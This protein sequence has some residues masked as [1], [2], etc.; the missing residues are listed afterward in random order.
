[1]ITQQQNSIN[2]PLININN[3][4]SGGR[5]LPTN[6]PIRS[7]SAIGSLGVGGPGTSDPSLHLNAQN[8]I[9][10]QPPAAHQNPARSSHPLHGSPI[11][12]PANPIQGFRGPPRAAH[13]SSKIPVT[14]RVLGQENLPMSREKSPMSIP[15]LLQQQMPGLIPGTRIDEEMLRHPQM[16]N[17]N[18]KR[19]SEMD[20][21]NNHLPVQTLLSLK[22]QQ[23]LALKRSFTPHFPGGNSNGNAP[24]NTSSPNYHPGLH[25]PPG[26]HPLDSHQAQHMIHSGGPLANRAPPP[27][28]M[29]DPHVNSRSPL[30]P[31][32]QAIYSGPPAHSGSMGEVFKTP[33]VGGNFGSNGN[34]SPLNNFPGSMPP[35]TTPDMHKMASGTPHDMNRF[36]NEP[37]RGPNSMNSLGLP[38]NSSS[39]PSDAQLKQYSVMMNAI[40]HQQLQ[41]HNQHLLMTNRSGG[42]SSPQNNMAQNQR[43]SPHNFSPS[44]SNSQMPINEGLTLDL[45]QQMQQPPNY[46]PMYT[47]SQQPSPKP[48]SIITGAASSAPKKS[49]ARSKASPPGSQG[50]E[51]LKSGEQNPELQHQSESHAQRPNGV[52]DDQLRASLRKLQ[53]EMQMSNAAAT[54]AQQQQVGTASGKQEDAAAANAASTSRSSPLGA[55]L[56]SESITSGNSNADVGSDIISD[57]T[58][59]TNNNSSG[60]ASSSEKYNNDNESKDQIKGLNYNNNQQ[61]SINEPFNIN[62]TK[63]S[64]NNLAPINLQEKNILVKQESVPDEPDTPTEPSKYQKLYSK[65]AW[66]KNYEQED[67]AARSKDSSIVDENSSTASTADMA[68]V[69]TRSSLGG[70]KPLGSPIEETSTAETETKSEAL[71]K[72]RRMPKR[73][74]KVNSDK[75]DNDSQQQPPSQKK[76]TSRALKHARDA[77]RRRAKKE[78]QQQKQKQEQQ[79]SSD[80]APDGKDTRSGDYNKSASSIKREHQSDDEQVA[81]VAKRAKKQK[82][83]SR[84]QKKTNGSIFLQTD[85]C[86]DIV[87]KSIRCLECRRVRQSAIKNEKNQQ[88]KNPSKPKA[89]WDDF[90][91]FFEFRKLE[92]TKDATNQ[93]AVAGFSDLNDAKPSDKKLWLPRSGYVPS[94]ITYKV[95]RYILSNVGDEFCKLVLQE[96]GVRE[97]YDK[98]GAS[99][100]ITW[101]R[102]VNGLRELCDV[103]ST[104]LFNCHYVCERCGFVVCFDCSNLRSKKDRQASAAAHAI[105]SAESESNSP[106]SFIK[107]ET[108]QTSI[109][110]KDSANGDDSIAADGAKDQQPATAAI[111]NG[112]KRSKKDKHGWI[113]CAK[114]EEHSYDKLV[115]AQIVAGDCLEQLWTMLHDIRERLDLGKCQCLTKANATTNVTSANDNFDDLEPRLT[116]VEEAIEDDVKMFNN[117]E[118]D[119]DISQDKANLEQAVAAAINQCLDNINDSTD[120]AKSE[121]GKPITNGDPV[122]DDIH[123]WLCEKDL[124]VLQHPRHAMNLQ[125]FRKQWKQSKPVL[126]RDVI[127]NMDMEMWAPKFFSKQ[128]GDYRSDLVDTRNGD[129]H[130]HS[131][132]KFWDGFDIANNGTNSSSSNKQRKSKEQVEDKDTSI[133]SI[134]SGSTT[135]NNN[136]I[137]STTA[138]SSSATIGDDLSIGTCYYNGS[139][140]WRL[141]DWPPGVDFKDVLPKHYENFMKSLPLPDYTT[142]TGKLNLSCRL[143]KEMLKPDLGPKMY[144]AYGTPKFPERGTTNLHLDIS[145]A[146]NVMIY[147]G[148][149]NSYK[150]GSEEFRE[151]YEKTIDECCCDDEMKQQIRDNKLIPGALWHIFKPS[152]AQKMRSFLNKVAEER[153]ISPDK[154]ADPIHDQTWYLD[155]VLLNRLFKEYGVKSY[156]ILQCMGDAILIPAGA[157]HQVKNLQNCIKVAN[158]FVSPENVRYCLQLTDEFRNLPETHINQEDKLQ[159]KNILYHSIKESI[160]YIQMFES[161]KMDPEDESATNTDETDTCSTTNNN[162]DIDEQPD[163]R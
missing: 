132:K 112:Q 28:G 89:N 58:G 122:G 71:K 27:A 151:I 100:R 111:T 153:N 43:S 143:P 126:V 141:K 2:N 91:R 4:N 139:P 34:P 20:Q 156:P 81:P 63:K 78:Q 21:L 13:M 6:R 102:A 52:L 123:S 114:S 161:G 16:D 32:M 97:L 65:K 134:A 104:T 30:N 44:M 88:A 69:A 42:S 103:C 160:Q 128:Y 96:R 117:D 8:Q 66:L 124:M 154:Q 105:Q 3:P 24:L 99:K 136:N 67:Q 127:K 18:I 59:A 107:K 37:P 23:E 148:G 19:F 137:T 98:H 22:Q 51:N 80:E 25:M 35:P 155:Q 79:D 70:S 54:V 129:I 45:K 29:M 157:P 11:S 131:M 41:Q 74:V 85:P 152:D 142:R 110:G 92:F 87:P 9:T 138:P 115:L 15:P 147:V 17:N 84:D 5:E 50:P 57:I 56:S 125:L 94:N 83:S 48:R 106:D 1:M 146:V 108:S 60:K 61:Q 76:E 40:Q 163:D 82:L 33:N 130:R 53:A 95:A 120:E 135:I 113:Y 140:L 73:K 93:Y 158:D 47:Q 36:L 90:C 39:S 101:K 150:E 49:K 144:S 10:R 55:V 77:A 118:D 109:D 116:I 86:Y 7:G 72:V 62:D 159:I 64:D 75:E 38:S 149:A 162:T 12:N 121:S 14:P 145:D 119:D 46:H 31:H 68:P 133:Q 26:S